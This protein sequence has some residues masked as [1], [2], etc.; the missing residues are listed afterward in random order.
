MPREP[1]RRGPSGSSAAPILQIEKLDV[2][3]GRAHVLQGVSLSLDHGVLAVVGRNGM[4]KSTLCNAITGLVPG[5]GAVRFA[6]QDILGLPPNRITN[7]GIAYVPQGRRVWPSL[8]VDEHLRLVQ[9]SGAKGPWT[10]SRIYQL[11]PRL[12]ERRRNGGGQLSGGK[13]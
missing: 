11:F 4:G 9:R 5:S 12:A 7:L 2:H 8:T 3:F 10:V 1:R 13:S 6:G